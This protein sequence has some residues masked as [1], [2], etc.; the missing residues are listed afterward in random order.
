MSRARTLRAAA[1]PIF[2]E[3]TVTRV[4]AQTRD[5]ERV[6]I[7]VD[8]T[9]W[10]GVHREVLRAH[11]VEEGQVLPVAMQQALYRAELEQQARTVALHYLAHRPRT[12]HEVRRR[13]ERAGFPEEVIDQVVVE[14]EVQ[15]FLDDRAYAQAYVQERLTA[16]GYGPQRLRAELRRRGVSSDIIAAALA[17]TQAEV[18]LLAVA[19]PLARRRWKLLCQTE[20]DRRKRR[21]KLLAF[22]QRRGFSPEIA[23]TLLREL[24]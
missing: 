15:G 13:L 12:V 16:R 18:D 2:R 19:R 14:L 9:F 21:Q 8:G 3:G 22:L 17:A 5:P 10:M 11:P 6:S 20:P 23:Y 24:D 1:P 7:F 4:V